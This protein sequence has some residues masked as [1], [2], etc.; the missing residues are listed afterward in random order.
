MII[1]R[2]LQSL[3]ILGTVLFLKLTTLGLKAVI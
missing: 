1:H 3:I 2:W